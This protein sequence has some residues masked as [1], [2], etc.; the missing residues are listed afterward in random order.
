[1]RIEIKN[2]SSVRKCLNKVLSKNISS[3]FNGI[4]ID[5]RQLKQGDIFIAI[6]GEKYHGN[7]FINQQLLDIAS[8]II[9]DKT[10]KID[11]PFFT[12]VN[13]CSTLVVTLS[14]INILVVIIL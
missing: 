10:L 11:S 6:Q 13:F 12:N 7:E 5:S 3:K 9:S 8:F 2:K 14:Q 1:M 4:S